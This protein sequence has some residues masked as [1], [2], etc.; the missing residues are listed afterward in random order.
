MEREADVLGL[1]VSEY[2]Y[3]VISSAAASP[4]FEISTPSYSYTKA[5]WEELCRKIKNAQKLNLSIRDK[6]LLFKIALFALDAPSR[7]ETKS[8]IHGSSSEVS[9]VDPETSGSEG[10][11]AG[12]SEIST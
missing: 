12:K 8:I 11:D 5:G 7:F 10:V 3:L 2:I 9:N 1:S 6:S 4:G